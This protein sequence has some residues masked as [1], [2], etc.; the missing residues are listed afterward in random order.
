[1]NDYLHENILYEKTLLWWWIPIQA[2]VKLIMKRSWRWIIIIII[3]IWR[4]E[5]DKN[6]MMKIRMKDEGSV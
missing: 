6:E 2:F 5:D 4:K 3:I 1:M